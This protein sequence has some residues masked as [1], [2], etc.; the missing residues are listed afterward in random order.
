MDYASRG[1]G[2]FERAPWWPPLVRVLVVPVTPQFPKL[3]SAP[4]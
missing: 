1:K 2:Y 4:S 3:A